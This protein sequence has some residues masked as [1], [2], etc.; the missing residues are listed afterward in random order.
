ME[1]C[2]GLILVIA[3]VACVIACVSRVSSIRDESNRSSANT[4][5]S[6][7]SYSSPAPRAYSSDILEY[8][9]SGS[10]PSYARR[11]K[12]DIEFVDYEYRAYI[13]ESPGY[14]NRATDGLSTHRH[15]DGRYYVCWST[16]VRTRTDMVNI[17]RQWSD[18]TQKYIEYG[19]RF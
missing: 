3:V 6:L 15:Y 13:L 2:R 5:S 9:A 19:T 1:V 12:F 4:F 17:A 11:Y 7:H 16:P 8:T 10:S 18:C 14:R